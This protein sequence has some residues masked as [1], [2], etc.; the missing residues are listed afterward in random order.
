MRKIEVRARADAPPDR[1]WAGLMRP[2]PWQAFHAGM[3]LGIPMRVIL[4]APLAL[5][6]ELAVSGAFGRGL[7]ALY[8]VSVWKPATELEIASCTPQ[9]GLIAGHSTL[10]L[11][12]TDEGDGRTD[13]LASYHEIYGNVLLEALS[14]VPFVPF[15]ARVGLE[16][17]L[18]GLLKAAGG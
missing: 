3:A 13:V 9:R 4:Q 11:S 5:G 16:R 18:L 10:S 8:R 17:G 6:V 1:L 12:L 14:W 15:L 7:G 2:E